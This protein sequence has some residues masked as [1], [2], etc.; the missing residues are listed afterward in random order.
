M[1]R[2]FSSGLEPAKEVGSDHAGAGV[3]EGSDPA[4]EWD[5]TAIKFGPVL[6]ALEASGADLGG[7][8]P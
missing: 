5:E 3:V 8:S 1:G 4:A 7:A 6:R 2:A